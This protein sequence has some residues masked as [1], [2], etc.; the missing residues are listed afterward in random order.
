M[1][2]EVFDTAA[3]I[4]VVVGVVEHIAA[5]AIVGSI[6]VNTGVGCIVAGTVVG[7]TVVDI[8]ALD[9]AGPQRDC[10]LI[11]IHR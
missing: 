5:V 3:D 1:A 6:V 9:T 8:A 2:P 7:C 4:V 10:H 11:P